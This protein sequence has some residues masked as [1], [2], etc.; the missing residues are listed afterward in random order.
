MVLMIQ[1]KSSGKRKQCDAKCYAAKTKRC[2]CI[3]GGKNHG[4]GLEAAAELV[5]DWAG[6]PEM[7]EGFGSAGVL[8]RSE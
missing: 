2:K 7:R 3:C 1:Y 4:K 8:L 6:D 5:R